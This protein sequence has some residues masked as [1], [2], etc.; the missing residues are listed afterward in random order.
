MKILK[1]TLIVPS[2]SSHE[3]LNFFFENMI[4]WTS[5]PKEI[6]LINT[7]KSKKLN[8]DSHYK[9]FLNKKKILIKFLHYPNFFPGAARNI[10][11]KIASNKIISFL[12][13]GT[14]ASKDWL[15]NG[16]N[17][18][19]NNKHLISWGYTYYLTT[20]KKDEIIRASTYGAKPLTT[21]PGSIVNKKVFNIVGCFI[22][23]IRAGEDAEW[24]HRVDL[25]NVK[26][27]VNNKIVVY[28]NLLG[29]SYLEILKKWFR[30]YSF[31]RKL[32]Y[33]NNNREAYFLSFSLILIILAFNWNPLFT[34]WGTPG[35]ENETTYIPHITK[36]TMLTLFLFYAFI[37]AIYIPIK[38][39]IDIGFLLKFN[40]L[41]ILIFS[42]CIDITKLISFFYSRFK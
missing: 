18:L 31:S 19:K 27:C 37:R 25:H 9:N 32:S 3:S 22:G 26:T 42:F 15:E 39:G 5:L 20:S 34:N 4:T 2:N 21:L 28:Q 11:L 23:N 24:R 36:I 29:V 7:N 30:N 40:I 16:Y 8:I 13:V 6:I 1:T 38:K 41:K 17:Q 14:H 33:L 35:Y 10:G 12:D